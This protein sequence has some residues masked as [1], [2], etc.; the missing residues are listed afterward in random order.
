MTCPLLSL[1][2]TKMG[3]LYSK[4]QGRE[5]QKGSPHS[6][7]GHLPLEKS[8]RSLLSLFLSPTMLTPWG[9]CGTLNQNKILFGGTGSFWLPWLA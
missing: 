3:F 9:H 1:F 7:T 6:S 4:Y 2:K 5:F 8:A